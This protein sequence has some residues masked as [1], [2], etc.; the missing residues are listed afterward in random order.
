M[1]I[2]NLSP[3]DRYAVVGKTGSGKSQFTVIL[4]YMFANSLPTPWQVWWID[5]KNVKEDLK[6]LR[7]WGACNGAS[8]TDMQ[9]PGALNNFLYFRIKP[10]QGFSVV[11]LAQSKIAEAYERGHVIVVVDEYT[12]VVPSDRSE[13]YGLQDV[14]ARGRGK[15]VGLIGLTQE[16]V[17][18]PR[19][20]LSQASH[21]ILFTVTYEAD[22]KYLRNFNKNYVPPQEQGDKYGFYWSHIDGTAQWAYYENQKKW[23]EGLKFALPRK[24]KVEGVDAGA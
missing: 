24:P 21:L 7:S 16:P 18:V 20:L 1:A 12:Q 2:A 15:N 13:G 10:T 17:Y 14:H 3:N 5:T 9:R 23:A 6:L 4:A 8:D 19:K 11:D 22:K